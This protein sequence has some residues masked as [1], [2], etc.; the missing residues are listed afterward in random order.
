MYNSPLITRIPANHRTI[1][2]RLPRACNPSSLSLCALVL[3]VVAMSVLR[4]HAQTYDAQSQLFFDSTGSD[5]AGFGPNEIITV[6]GNLTYTTGCGDG[7]DDSWIATIADIYVVRHN[8]SSTKLTDVRGSPTVIRSE[9]GGNAFLEDELAA[10]LLT[11]VL[12]SGD[13]DVIIDECQNGFWDQSTDLRLGGLGD[14]PAFSVF[15]P[16]NVANI[17]ARAC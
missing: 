7:R 12:G 8:T 17:A 3:G 4:S 6:S 11:G 9:F 16:A 13:Y 1:A 10:T 5:Q 14:S 2:A 15:I